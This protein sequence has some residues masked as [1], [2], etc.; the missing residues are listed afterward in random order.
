MSGV[1]RAEVDEV[2]R[3]PPW[4]QLPFLEAGIALLA[5]DV[6][7]DRRRVRVPVFAEQGAQLRLGHLLSKRGTEGGKAPAHPSTDRKPSAPLRRLQRFAAGRRPAGSVAPQRPSHG[8]P[9]AGIGLVSAARQEEYTPG[10]SVFRIADEYAAA[11][12][13]PMFSV[14][15]ARSKIG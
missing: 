3:D 6:V 13:P 8:S 12:L 2:R 11:N 5:T 10:A 9:P 15:L 14:R 1:D 4:A 7:L